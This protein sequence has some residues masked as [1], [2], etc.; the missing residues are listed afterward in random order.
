MALTRRI[1]AVVLAGGPHDAVAALAPD[2]PNKAFVPIAREA[3]VS[4]TIAAL[5]SAPSIGRIIVVAPRAAHLRAE[6]ERADERRD[7]GRTMS[8]SLRSGLRGL[9][10]DELVLV[11]ASDLP[12]LDAVAL[13]EFLAIASARSADVTYA[14]VERRTHVARFPDVPHTWARLLGGTYCGGGCVAL[15]PR[16]LPALDR[17]LGR[18]GAARKNPLRLASIFGPDVL[19]RYA[20]RRLT[21]AQAEARASQ[22]LAAPVAAAICAYPQIAVNV[23]RISDVALA[24]RL[25]AP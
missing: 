1:D 19:L 12:V 6:L 21:I 24:E 23:D 8:E 20:L 16:V 9:P 14:C 25:V 7:D 5:H 13:E 10:A 22:L 18:L 2:A 15:R 11:C 3:L 4:R 17:L